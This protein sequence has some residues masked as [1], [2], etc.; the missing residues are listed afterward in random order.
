MGGS[1]R[2]NGWV[3]EGEWVGP[4]GWVGGSSGVNGLFLEGEWVGPRG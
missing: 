2:V 3:L 4:L 1:S